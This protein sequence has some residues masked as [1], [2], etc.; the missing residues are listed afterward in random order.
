MDDLEKVYLELF[1]SHLKARK[2]KRRT[3][4][5]HEYE[6]HLF[7]NLMNTATALCEKRYHPSRGIAFI[8]RRPVIREIFAAPYVDRV[9]HHYIFD[10]VIDYWERQFIYDSY[11]CRKNKGTLMGIR[12][13]EHFV[14]KASHNFTQKT[15]VFKYDLSGYF[16]SLPRRE[17]YRKA[18]AGLKKQYAGHNITEY[19]R[20]KHIWHQVIFDDPT[21]GVRVRGSAKDWRALPAKKSL[22]KQAPGYGIVIGNLTSQLLSNIF[23][24]DFDHYMKEWLHFR[25]YGRYVDD[26]YVLVDETERVTTLEYENHIKNYL[27][28]QGV[29][30]NRQKTYR[31]E[32]SKGTAFLGVVIYPR[33]TVAGQRLR[34]NFAM[35]TE[36]FCRGIGS[37]D[38]MFS[39]A[40]FL[41]HHDCHN[42]TNAMFDKASFFCDCLPVAHHNDAWH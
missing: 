20:L 40:G 33:R 27:A 4:D 16:M 42:L 26:F 23:L 29:K 28:R 6:L 11:S 34:Q 32:I 37:A 38:T 12:R 5:E 35:A 13:M 31:Q 9:V 7:E 21:D 1:K 15:Y 25:Y 18:T 24:N 8:I 41:S 17:L 19:R 3:K 14:R 10:K 36:S 30:M 39:Y 2:A 22:F